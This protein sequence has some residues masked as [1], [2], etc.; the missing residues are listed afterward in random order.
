MDAKDAY[1]RTSALLDDYLE[2]LSMEPV[3]L[4]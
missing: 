3:A 4:S 1:Q 2:P